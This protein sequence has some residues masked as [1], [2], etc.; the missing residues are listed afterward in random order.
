M[1]LGR[2]LIFDTLVPL[3]AIVTCSTVTCSTMTVAATIAP[4]F[5]DINA[6]CEAA[7]HKNVEAIS[8]CVVAESEA[9]SEVLR[10]WAKVSDADATTC[11]KSSRK[12]KR[13]P[14]VALA[15]CLSTDTTAN[16]VPS[17]KP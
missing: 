11:L 14:Y 16:T 12:S 4:P 1:P 15:R 13:L 7:H 2:V 10:E 17:A 6:Q 5:L 3:V 8:E 9:R